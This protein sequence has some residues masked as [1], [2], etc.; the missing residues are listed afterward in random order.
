MGIA[1]DVARDRLTP[2]SLVLW[3]IKFSAPSFIMSPVTLVWGCLVNVLTG[4]RFHNCK[5]NPNPGR[6]KL[7]FESSTRAV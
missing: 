5:E 3:H 1:Y 4:T 2:K 7:S 6:K